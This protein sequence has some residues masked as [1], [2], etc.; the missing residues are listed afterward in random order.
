MDRLTWTG[1]RGV[2]GHLTYHGTRGTSGKG[3]PLFSIYWDVSH[4]TKVGN[5]YRLISY[6]PGTVGLETPVH[7]DNL[8]F[9]RNLAE[10]VFSDWLRRMD[11][12]PV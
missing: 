7:S 8:E 12:K 9:L 2:A 6:L 3:F 11:L 5:S 10:S 4:R 1:K